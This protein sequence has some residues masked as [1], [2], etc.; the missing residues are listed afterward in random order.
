MTVQIEPI[1]AAAESPSSGWRLSR[2]DDQRSLSEVY[3]TIPVPMTASWFRRLLAF[4]G[5]GLLIAG[6][7]VAAM[8]CQVTVQP[9]N[10]GNYVPGDFAPLDITG[11]IDVRCTGEDG[12]FV[13]T[14]SAGGSGSFA[15]RQ[16]VSGPNLMRYNFYIDPSR[17]M[18]S[19]TWPISSWHSR[20]AACSGVSPSSTLPAGSSH[21]QRFTA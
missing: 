1:K 16:M 11:R 2:R 3:A 7:A 8:N 17:T 12:V 4:S 9:F 6:A 13:A 20:R 14:L 19:G 15:Q 5:P 21:S 10:F 18:V